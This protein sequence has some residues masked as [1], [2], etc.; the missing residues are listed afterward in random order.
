MTAC[1]R[2]YSHL[3]KLRATCQRSDVD[4]AACKKAYDEA[5]AGYEG[6]ED[7][8]WRRYKK[9][10]AEQQRRYHA[11]R[12]EARAS[13]RQFRERMAKGGQVGPR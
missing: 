5:P 7:K 11:Q 13:S 6:E 1:G 4:C 12:A 10:T 3:G 2:K 8:H 9:P